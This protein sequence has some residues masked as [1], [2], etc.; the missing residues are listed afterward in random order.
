MKNLINF[1]AEKLGRASY[2][3][4]PSIPFP[5][6]LVVMF[7]RALQLL[8]GCVYK[9]L[10][11]KQLGFLFLGKKCDL[12]CKNLITLG[13]SVIIGNSVT[14]NALSK[15]GVFIGNNVTIKDNTI[16]ECTG[17]M[18][19]IGEGLSIGDNV[20]ISQN[21][22]IQ[23]RGTVQ[24]EDNVIIGPG[25]SI[26][27]ENH[28]YRNRDSFI[29]CQGVDRKGV[30]IDKGAWIGAN[31]TILDGVTIGEGSIVAAGSVVTKNVEPYAIVGGSPA[32][33]IKY[34]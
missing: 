28:V 25:V 33:I 15:D 30:A 17:V 26:F 7:E 5:M 18:T 9:P 11:K 22:F 32:K 23:V 4:D 31:A 2:K 24:I 1:I 10:F 19:N 20:G 27:S 12:K 6:L 29:S 8:R 16:I 21:C 13:R 34:R 3:V 14:I